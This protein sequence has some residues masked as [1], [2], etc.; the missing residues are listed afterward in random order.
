MAR[1]I[2]LSFLALMVA[3]CIG[4][5][6]IAMAGAALVVTE[7]TAASALVTPAP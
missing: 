3:F 5:S 1:K 7:N 4:F 6:L 2:A